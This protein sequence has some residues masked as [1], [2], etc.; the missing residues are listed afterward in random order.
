MDTSI[1]EE[2]WNEHAMGKGNQMNFHHPEFISMFI[3]ENYLAL[4]LVICIIIY[5]LWSSKNSPSHERGRMSENQECAP[6]N[7]PWQTPSNL[8][9]LFKHPYMTEV[10]LGGQWRKNR[11]SNK[12]CQ[13]N[14][15]SICKSKIRLWHYTCRTKFRWIK[16]EI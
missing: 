14:W 1:G 13:D 7:L 3:D 11:L 15:I 5:S 9:C 2:C 12:C 10:T 8:I 4:F 6:R 16:N